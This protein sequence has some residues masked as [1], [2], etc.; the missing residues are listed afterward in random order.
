MKK[1]F[2]YLIPYWWMIIL[3]LATTAISV[4]SQ[5]QLPSITG[6][7]VNNGINH[8]D[9]KG[10]ISPDMNYIWQHGLIMI[11]MVVIGAATVIAAGYFAS[12]IGTGWAKRLRQEVFEKVENFSQNE[13]NKFSTASLITRSTNDIQQIQQTS[14]L[15]LRMILQSPIMAAYSII[16]AVQQ[17][18]RLSWIMWL[19]MATMIIILV[20]VIILVVPRFA[21]IQELTDNLNLASRENLTGLRIIRAFR[22]ERFEEKKFAKA[23]DAL[24]ETTL[25]VNRVIAVMFP[26]VSFMITGISLMITWFMAD[27]IVNHYVNI[28]DMVSFPQYAIQAIMSFIFIAMLMIFIPRAAVSVKRIGEI[29]DTENSVV[30]TKDKTVF[31]KNVPVGTVEFKNVDF[32]YP[33]AEE[34]TLNGISFVAE[35]GKTTA[36]IGSTGSG[37]STLIQLIPRFYDAKSGQIFINGAEIKKIAK[38]DLVKTVGYIPQK[39]V[40]FSGTVASNI[41]EKSE[42]ITDAEIEEVAK[43]AEADSFIRK[44]EGGYKSRIAQGGTNVSGGQRQRISIARALAGNPDVLIFDDSFSALDYATDKKVRKNL[45]KFAK[46][47]TVIIVAQRISTIKDAVQIIVLDDGKIDAIG[48]HYDLLNSSK[49][50]REIAESQF[51]ESE[52]ADEMKTAKNHAGGLR[53]KGGK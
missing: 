11:G 47:K 10:V 33:G 50:Y 52:F 9:A 39:G 45:E 29:L 37:K 17:A 46:D 36:V 5:L 19:G 31:A 42:K 41:R 35:P 40:L 44:L 26:L 25:W 7:I 28:G 38:D 2:K 16:L 4:W 1:V 34:S 48:T 30:F 13:I 8:V 14:I 53:K 20:L 51:A 6:D 22:N 18:P 32:A 49:T 15:V 23:N 12:K 43:V 27:G 24:T 3:I 21:K